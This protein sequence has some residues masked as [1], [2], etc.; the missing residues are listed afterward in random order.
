MDRYIGLD[1]HSSSCTLG[2]VSS[3][4]K[5]L[6][7]QVL[8]TNANVLIDLIRTIPGNRHLCLKEGTLSSR[9]YEVHES[10]RKQSSKVGMSVSQNL[11]EN[12]IVIVARRGGVLRR[13]RSERPCANTELPYSFDIFF[14]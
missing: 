5:R 7:T 9:L 13:D 14:N 12:R 11:G 2:V 3:S 6:Q 4:G 10:L 8:E 1:A